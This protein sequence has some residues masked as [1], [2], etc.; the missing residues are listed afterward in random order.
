M[1]I[2]GKKQQQTQ[3]PELQEYYASKKTESTGLAWLL[4]LGS[5]LLTAAIF[6]GLFLGGRWIYRSIT[7]DDK[8]T[9]GTSQTSGDKN[10]VQS[11]GSVNT[12]DTIKATPTQPTETVTAPKVETSVGGAVSTP[13]PVTSSTPAQ[14][15]SPSQS[16]QTNTSAVAATTSI[17]NTGP[18]TTLAVFIAVLV[19]STYAHR[20]YTLRK[21]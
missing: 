19:L 20:R 12:G 4:A 8:P 7:N 17:P 16:D 5:L 9:S 21:N 15:V 13:T 11:D 18:T 1:A 6:I 10:V 14:G 2:F 3:I